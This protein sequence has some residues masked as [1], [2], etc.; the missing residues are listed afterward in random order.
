MEGGKADL[1]LHREELAPWNTENEADDEDVSWYGW[2]V[3]TIRNGVD[4][5]C[6]R[7]AVLVCHVKDRCIYHAPLAS[8][9]RLGGCGVRLPRGM[10]SP[11]ALKLYLIK[12]IQV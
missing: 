12:A 7:T 9:Q 5:L 2:Y 4:A 8:S 6:A 11:A 10:V 1:S 3:T